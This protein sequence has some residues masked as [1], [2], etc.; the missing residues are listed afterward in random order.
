M[1]VVI[2]HNSVE[3]SPHAIVEMVSCVIF[4]P[5]QSGNSHLHFLQRNLYT[6][7]AECSTNAPDMCNDAM[8]M[9]GIKTGRCNN[10]ARKVSSTFQ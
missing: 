5:I 2:A 4:S 7:H 3:I 1:L 8:Q 9:I 6:Y 10:I